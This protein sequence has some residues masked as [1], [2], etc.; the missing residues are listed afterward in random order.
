MP[1]GNARCI[2]KRRLEPKRPAK[3]VKAVSRTPGDVRKPGTRTTS[4]PISP[5]SRHRSHLWATANYRTYRSWHHR[6]RSGPAETVA[7]SIPGT[8]TGVLENV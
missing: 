8:G 6:E 3:K 2:C 4:F 7:N 1:R 5:G